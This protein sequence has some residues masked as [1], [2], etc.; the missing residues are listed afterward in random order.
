VALA[1]TEGIAASTGFAMYSSAIAANQL[2]QWTPK[3]G[4][5]VPPGCGFT[6]Q[7]SVAAS[8]LLANVEWFEE[9]VT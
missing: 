2:M 8:A 3:G 6:A 9:N 7:H 5:I 4:L 1:K